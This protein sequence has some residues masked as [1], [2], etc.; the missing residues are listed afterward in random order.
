LLVLIRAR[1]WAS[2]KS[3]SIIFD[4]SFFGGLLLTGQTE[5]LLS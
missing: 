2:F 3:P 5:K 1:A 4:K